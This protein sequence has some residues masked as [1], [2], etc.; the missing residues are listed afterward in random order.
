MHRYCINSLCRVLTW[1]QP[2]KTLELG[3]LEGRVH[4]VIGQEPVHVVDL[5]Q[6]EFDPQVNHVKNHQLVQSAS[7]WTSGH[8][9]KEQ[10]GMFFLLKHSRDCLV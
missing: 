8:V 5:T 4:S 2:Y 7:F 1:F 6:V 3:L 10:K 9:L